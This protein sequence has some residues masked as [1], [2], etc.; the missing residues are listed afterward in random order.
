MARQRS[1][2]PLGFYVPRV[3]L[4]CPVKG[5][6]PGLEQNL[7]ALTQFDYVQYEI[8]FAL[9]S[10]KDPAFARRGT[11]RRAS[12]RRV[13]I[14]HAGTPKDCG[15]KVN[16][17]RAAVEQAGGE[18]EVLVFADS[19]G[20]PPRRW[21]ARLVAPLADPRLGATTTFRWLLPSRGGFWSALVSAWNAPIATHLGNHDHNFCWGGG[22]AIRRD[23]FEEIRG[24]EAW[25]G[26]VSDDFSLTNALRSAGFGIAFVPECLVASPIEA[27][28]HKVFEFTSRQLIITRVYASK[29]WMQAL[30]GHA[31]YCL[32]VLL[33]LGIWAAEWASGAPSLQIL[34]LALLPPVLCSVRGILRLVAVLDLMPEWQAGA[35]AIQLGMDA[36]GASGAVPRSYTTPSWPGS[37]EGLLGAACAIYWSLRERHKSLLPKISNPNRYRTQPISHRVS[38]NSARCEKTLLPKLPNPH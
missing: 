6:E 27:D 36:V 31:L 30:A 25:F 8:F 9:A 13:H 28:A 24:L 2:S 18:F 12:K 35:V 22:T 20:R 11:H 34:L 38:E 1:A 17:L 19:D 16:N 3:A 14:V 26:S 10:D 4:L 7:S 37:G 15:E 5:L 32:T 21:L 23:R 33:G 29:I